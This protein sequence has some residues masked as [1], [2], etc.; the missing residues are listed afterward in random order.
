MSKL[1]PIKLKSEQYTRV[2]NI[3]W[4]DWGNV[5]FSKGLFIIIYLYSLYVP[6]RII[7]KYQDKW[8]Q[9]FNKRRKNL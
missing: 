3:I 2:R 8:Y 1:Q 4:K 9:P 5:S 6:K 7:K